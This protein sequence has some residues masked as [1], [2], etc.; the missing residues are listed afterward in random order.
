MRFTSSCKFN[1]IFTIIG[2]KY[3]ASSGR[4]AI[5]ITE[6]D[7]IQMGRDSLN[8]AL[9]MKTMTNP[10]KN[11]IIFVGDGMGISTTAVARIF[12]AQKEKKPVHKV[13]LA[14]EAMPYSALSRVMINKILTLIHVSSIVS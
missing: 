11:V 1:N 14:W 9:K 10:A 2:D 13:K 3:H 4:K 7:W 5:K 8:N 12:K 6:T